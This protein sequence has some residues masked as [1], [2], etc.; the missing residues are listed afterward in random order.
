MIQAQ[1]ER[2]YQDALVN[3]KEKIRE[4]E[5][6]DIKE[7]MQDQIRQWFIETR[8]CD[9]KGTHCSY[10]RYRRILYC[11]LHYSTR[12]PSAYDIKIHLA[13]LKLRSCLLELGYSAVSF[14]RCSVHLL[15]SV[16]I[17]CAG[18]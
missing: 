7:N 14:N 12:D 15:R 4:A 1:H 8:Y 6:P 5:G 10:S 2:E 9:L 17:K 18:I 3:I 11:I 13:Y 16:K